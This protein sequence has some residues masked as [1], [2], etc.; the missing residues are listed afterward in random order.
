MKTQRALSTVFVA[1][2]LVLAGT[3]VWRFRASAAPIPRYAQAQQETSSL[4]PAKPA[5]RKA[6]IASITAQLKAFARDDY[7]TAITY[8]SA[9]LKR[10]FASPDQF[11]AMMLTHYPAFAHNKAIRFGP[12]QSSP[13]GQH[14]TV[15]VI[16]TGPNGVQARALYVMVLEGK[17]YRVEGVLGGGAAPPMPSTPGAI[18][19]A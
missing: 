13:T 9:G 17:I 1:L 18:G 2:M 16:V 15:P 5:E 6:A 11:R 7:K 10:N 4:R 12:A 3:V 8:Q 14:V 19:N